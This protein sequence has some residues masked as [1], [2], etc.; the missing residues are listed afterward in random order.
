MS[1]IELSDDQM[2]EM[3]TYCQSCLRFHKAM[4]KNS[5]EGSFLQQM[6]KDQTAFY[7]EQVANLSQKLNP[8]RR[9]WVFIGTPIC[10]N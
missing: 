3:L 5:P 1:S 7:A 6:H 4:A 8:P 2:S 10:L 9:R